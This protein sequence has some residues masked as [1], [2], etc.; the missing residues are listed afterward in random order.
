YAIMSFGGFL[1]IGNR[2]H[3]L[4]WSALR[5]DPEKQGY[6]VSIDMDTLRNAPHY[7]AAELEGLGG[8]HPP[9]LQAQILEYYGPYGH[10]PF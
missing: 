5:Y 10:P 3:P 8:A 1:G 7:D 4:P 6:V 9:E 2:L